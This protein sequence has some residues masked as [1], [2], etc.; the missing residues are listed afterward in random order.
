MHPYEPHGK[1]GG[2]GI[3]FAYPRA[4]ANTTASAD[5]WRGEVV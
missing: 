3:G 1:L 4:E 2:C 5:D